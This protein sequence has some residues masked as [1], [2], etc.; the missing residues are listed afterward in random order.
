MNPT[1]KIFIEDGVPNRAVRYADEEKKVLHI[2]YDDPADLVLDVD[3]N[4]SLKN[5]WGNR[6]IWKVDPN[7]NFCKNYRTPNEV[8]ESIISGRIL[9]SIFETYAEK[10]SVIERDFPIIYDIQQTALIKKRKFSYLDEGDEI[11]IDRWQNNE[12]EHWRKLTKKNEK[13]SLSL[14]LNLGGN[15]SNNANTFMK[16]MISFSI[17]VD[18]LT[19]AGFHV[20]ANAIFMAAYSCSSPDF[21]FSIATFKLKSSNQPLDVERMLTV[22][23]GG[24]FRYYVFMMMSSLIPKM[25]N[26]TMGQSQHKGSWLEDYFTKNYNPDVFADGLTM[27]SDF[28]VHLKKVHY[29]VK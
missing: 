9:P 22:G 26:S 24:F 11:D 15:S 29:I 14:Y 20:E 1:F 28:S 12:T 23:A 6:L 25:K 2:H 17:L 3:E 16:N 5:G 21:S 10:K 27:Q 18:L 8:A 4:L 13:R 7:F 19:T